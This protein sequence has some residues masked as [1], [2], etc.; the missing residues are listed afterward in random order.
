MHGEGVH[1]LR[2]IL[3]GGSCY[4]PLTTGL[5]EY[6]LNSTNGSA[7]AKLPAGWRVMSAVAHLK[8]LLNL[9][10]ETADGSNLWSRFL[11][12]R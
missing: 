5:G 9:H 1:C 8:G 12:S 4:R 6:N 7:K 10:G 11:W 3:K 2:A